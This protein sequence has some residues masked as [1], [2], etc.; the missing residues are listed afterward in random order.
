VAYDHPATLGKEEEAGK[1]RG[2]EA[3]V[4]ERGAGARREERGEGRA[5]FFERRGG[6]FAIIL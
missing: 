2:A 5:V 4:A 6:D 1:R 3:K